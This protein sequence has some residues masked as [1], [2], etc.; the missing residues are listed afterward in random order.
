MSEVVKSKPKKWLIWLRDFGIVAIIF[1][2]ISAW[3]TRNMLE[4]DG[5]INIPT[6][7]LV[8]LK[9]NVEPLWSQKQQNLIYFFAPWCQICALSID[10]LQYLNDKK[11]NIVVVALDYQSLEEVQAFVD[12]HEVSVTV[13]MG[14]TALKQEF[15]IQGYPSYYLLDE[16]G[17]ITSR[18]FG[19]STAL[20][21]KMRE[22]FGT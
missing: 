1:F 4:T 7:N 3:Q 15:A 21:L 10:N 18:A 19:Y 6:Q 17:T 8:S 9:G 13:L 2:V 12:E 22:A 20:G 14:T 16:K 5:S 11:V